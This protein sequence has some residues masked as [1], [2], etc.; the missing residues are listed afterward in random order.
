[1][2]FVGKDRCDNNRQPPNSFGHML[3]WYVGNFTPRTN[4]IEFE[5]AKENLMK[6]FVK[7]LRKEG[8]IGYII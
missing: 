7:W 8:L 2:F 1:M 4:D 3:E 5:A 6:E